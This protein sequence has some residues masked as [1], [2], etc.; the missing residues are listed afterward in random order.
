[1]TLVVFVPGGVDITPDAFTFTDVNGA[2]QSTLYTS[3]TIVVS[4]I[5]AATA[6]TISGGQYS[7][8]GGAYTASPGTVQSGDT[9]SVRVTSSSA[10][11]TAI[12]VILTIGGVSDTYTVTT[13]VNPLTDT[14]PDAFSFTDVTNATPSTVYTSNSITVSG[15]DTASPIS[16][17][18]GGTY[19]KNGSFYT[20]SP[21]TVANG[22]TVSVRA[23][24]SASFSTSVSTTLTIG[25]VSDIYSVTTQVADSV[26]DAFS[27]TDASGVELSTATTS[28]TITVAG[29]NTT[30][31]ISI[32][33]GTYSKNGGSFTAATD[34]VVLGDTVAVKA[35]SSGSYSTSVNVVLTIGGVSDTFTISTKADPGAGYTPTFYF[36]G[37]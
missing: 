30:A 16:I 18:G 35:T 29:I 2:T 24:S 25:G 11:L 37:F 27:F 20:S 3:N 22:D 15:I 31:T 36:L 26:P 12:N 17:S 28:N 4:G 6:I 5:A 19:S 10:Y 34:T 23:T 21:G 8:N 33:G 7:V 9:V 14:T 13:L 1:M 32:T